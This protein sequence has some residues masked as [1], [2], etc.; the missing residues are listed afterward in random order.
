MMNGLESLLPTTARNICNDLNPSRETLLR[1][2]VSGRHSRTF[3]LLTF[4][5]VGDIVFITTNL[6]KSG[7]AKKKQIKKKNSQ[8]VFFLYCMSEDFLNCLLQT[9]RKI[10]NS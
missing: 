7:K 10:E 4:I 9:C 3:I 5:K 8:M 1:R 2:P 6:P